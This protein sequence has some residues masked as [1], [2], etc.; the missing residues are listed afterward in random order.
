M[1]ANIEN[2]GGS[3]YPNS[4]KLD[5]TFIECDNAYKDVVLICEANWREQLILKQLWE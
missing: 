3:S 1:H 5:W 4:C 2:I